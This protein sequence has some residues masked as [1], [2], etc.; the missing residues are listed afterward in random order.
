MTHHPVGMTMAVCTSI[1]SS[2]PKRY[3]SLHEKTISTFFKFLLQKGDKTIFKFWLK[4]SKCFMNIAF[5]FAGVG[6]SRFW[7]SIAMNSTGSHLPTICPSTSKFTKS[8]KNNF[9][10]QKLIK[11]EANKC[12]TQCK[13]KQIGIKKMHPQN[14]IFCYSAN[15]NIYNRTSK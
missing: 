2:S 6:C 3:C 15:C 13:N 5:L 10:K 4:K 12:K 7:K 11:M 9:I 8:T 1:R 14:M